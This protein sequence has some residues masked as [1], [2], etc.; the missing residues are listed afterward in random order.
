MRIILSESDIKS[1]FLHKVILMDGVEIVVKDVNYDKLIN[2]ADEC[3]LNE[4]TKKQ[5]DNTIRVNK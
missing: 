2:I 3:R 1:L 4:L 5:V